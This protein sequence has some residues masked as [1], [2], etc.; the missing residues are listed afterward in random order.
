MDVREKPNQL[1]RTELKP[2]TRKKNNIPRIYCREKM[3][4]MEGQQAKKK[5][6]KNRGKEDSASRYL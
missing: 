4:E 5:Q 1:D 2:K 3:I 6:K